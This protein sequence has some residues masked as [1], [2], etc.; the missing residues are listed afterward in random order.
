MLSNMKVAMEERGMANF[1]ELFFCVR[2]IVDHWALRMYG[3]LWDVGTG[4][5]SLSFFSTP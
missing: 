3:V 5:N 2:L 4:Q 1:L